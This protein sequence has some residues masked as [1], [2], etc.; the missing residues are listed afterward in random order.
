MKKI[1][2]FG[3]RKGVSPLAASTSPG[4]SLGERPPRG[5]RGASPR[6]YHVR[7]RDLGKIHRAASV[8]SVAKVKQILLLRINGL[9][10]RDKMNR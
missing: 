10:D 6:G 3:S 1:F 2:G 7:D 8:G 9:N 5:G 4:R